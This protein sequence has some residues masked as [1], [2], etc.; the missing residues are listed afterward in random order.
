MSVTREDPDAEHHGEL[1]DVLAAMS[2]KAA[3]DAASRRAR[4]S[5][6]KLSLQERGGRV[7]RQPTVETKRVSITDTQ[8]GNF[9]FSLRISVTGSPRFLNDPNLIGDDLT[10][11]VAQFERRRQRKSPTD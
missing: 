1:A 8:V 2:V 3:P 9:L 7:V 5:D 4:L 6:R 11:A 10:F